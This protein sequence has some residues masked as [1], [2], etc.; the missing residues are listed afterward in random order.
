[1]SDRVIWYFVK[2]FTDENH[3]DQFVKGILYL[4]RL[5]FFKNVE[6][7]CDD[8]RSDKTE[9]VSMWWQP[10]DIVIDLSVPALGLHTRISPACTE[11]D[12]AGDTTDERCEDHRYRSATLYSALQYE[13]A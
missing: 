8:G 1:M 4:R 3:S 7:E 13:A 5:S 12:R 6:S 9:A 10:H 2:F 11:A